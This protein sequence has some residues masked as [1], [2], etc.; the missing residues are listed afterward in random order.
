MMGS[1]LQMQPENNTV[2]LL[3]LQTSIMDNIDMLAGNQS[4]C[5]EDTS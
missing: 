1:S 3:A 5:L 2:E 4:T